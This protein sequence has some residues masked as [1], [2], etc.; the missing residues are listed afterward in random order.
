MSQDT[1]LGF[2]SNGARSLHQRAGALA[3]SALTRRTG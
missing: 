2:G 3:G 1:T